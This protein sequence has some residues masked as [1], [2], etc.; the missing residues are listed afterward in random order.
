MT[1][2]HQAAELVTALIWPLESAISAFVICRLF[3]CKKRA[4]KKHKQ[5]DK[6]VGCVAEIVCCCA[7]TAPCGLIK[8]H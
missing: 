8:L 6:D 3:E 2:T 5:G 1:M 7:F 4:K